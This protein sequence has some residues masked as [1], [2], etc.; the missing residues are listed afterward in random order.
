MK[1]YTIVVTYN[2]LKWV[3]RCFGSLRNSEIP[4]HILAID[5]GSTDGTVNKLRKAYS[6]VELIENGTNLGFGQ[7]NN[8]G[9]AK[10][11]KDKADYVFLLNQDAWVK[12]DTIEK[13]I[14]VASNNLAYGVFSPI[15]LNGKGDELDRN[16]SH[17][18]LQN[19]GRKY[20]TD[21]LLNKP[22]KQI[23]ELDFVNAAAWLIPNE[24]LKKVG[25]FDPLFYHYGED[26]DYIQRLKYHGYKVSVITTSFIYH[27][28]EEKNIDWDINRQ[29]ISELLQMKNINIQPIINYSK[30]KKQYFKTKV[31][32]FSVIFNFNKKAR[33]KERLEILSRLIKIYNRIILSRE[34]CKTSQPNFLSIE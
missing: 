3:D 6:D 4:V 33:L 24:V 28:R 12:P 34:Q 22:V 29:Y 9:M 21:K 11:L 8:I 19:E 13:L 17:Y 18:L 2:G 5:N 30:L 16:F 1:I 32:S 10:A 25:G 31:K 23:I 20:L 27:D 15:H 14:S 7:A 26:D